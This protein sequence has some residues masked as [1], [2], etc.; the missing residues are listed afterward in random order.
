M[1]TSARKGSGSRKK[2]SYFYLDG[3]LNKTLETRRSDNLL[4][5]WNYTQGKRVAYVL[6]DVYRRRQ[7][8]FTTGQVAKMM[9]RHLDTIKRN[10]REGNIRYPQAAR[11][12]DGKDKVVRYL[13]SEEDVREIHDYFKTVHIGRPRKDGGVTTADLLSRAEL[14]ALMRNEKVL[15]TK[16]EDGTFVP[17]WKQ[18]EW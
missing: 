17:V 7:R 3:D 4:V 14:E 16:S 6:N 13:F 8:A 15:Y 2:W 5:A 10:L 1:V 9:G 11:S 12:L 18:P